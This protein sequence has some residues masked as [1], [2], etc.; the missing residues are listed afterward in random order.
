M[1]FIEGIGGTFVFS[2]RPRQL[3]EWYTN[4]LGMDFESNDANDYV[5]QTFLSANEETKNC[6]IRTSFSIIKAQQSF[7]RQRPTDEPDLMY[8]DQPFMINFRANEL[9]KLVDKLADLGIRI[10]KQQKEDHGHYVWLR[11]LDG[12]RVELYEPHSD[13]EK[14]GEEKEKDSGSKSASKSKPTKKKSKKS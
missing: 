3:A 9:T 14:R 10:I 8:G 5:F 13:D 2:H 4:Y 1:S 11:D 6:K 12:N 7:S